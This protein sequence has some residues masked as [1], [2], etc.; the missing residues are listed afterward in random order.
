MKK[1]W[2]GRFNKATDCCVEEFTASINFDK[3]LYRY[4]IEGSIAHCNML[5][6]CGII[7]QK[8]SDKIIKGLKEILADIESG[9]FEFSVALEDIH[10]NIEKSLIERIGPEGG[11]L[12]T[13]RSRNDQ[14]ALDMRLYLRHETDNVISLIELLQ[15]AITAFARANFG[16]IMPGY[17]HMQMA[18]PV[19]ISHHMLAYYDMLDRDMARFKELA[20][21]VNVLPLGSAALAGT[22]YPIDRKYTAKLLN[23]PKVS[24]NSIDSVSDRDFVIE[25]LSAASITMMHLSRLSEEIIIWSSSEFNFIDIDE[26]FCTGSS[27]MP[28]KK[29]P[30]VPELVRGKTGRVYGSLMSVLTTMKSLPL[31][32]NKD[33]QEDKEQLFD[34]VDTIKGS[35]AIYAS[36]I[37]HIKVNKERLAVVIL[38]GYMTA[39]DMADYL[40]MKGL[41]FR[42]AHEITG[43][44]VN[45]CIG[46][47]RRLEELTL[48]ELTKFSELFDEKIFDFIKVDNSVNNKNDIG[49]TS[50]LQ[51]SSRLRLLAKKGKKCE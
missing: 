25:F 3:R 16:I 4:D 20:K 46:K 36:M 17:T 33:L 14:I 27:I 24:T 44:V 8:E 30:D 10:M 26:T 48:T 12:H 21:R 15:D 38:G 31:A 40:A 45:Y 2:E 41:P 47:G 39:V 34:T 49:S 18:Q 35:L 13:A 1:A 23:F 32:Y 50:P 51:V 9:K 6:H 43:S 37:G 29:N 11:K 22:N 19:L 5:A 7:K 42:D 28:Q